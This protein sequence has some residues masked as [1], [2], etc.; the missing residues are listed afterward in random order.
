MSAVRLLLLFALLIAS[1][2]P[3]SVGAQTLKLIMERSP[4]ANFINPE[5][6]FAGITVDILTEV[7]NSVGV[8]IEIS[9]LPWRRAYQTALNEADTCVF[10]TA[11]LGTR[12]RLF[13]WV[14]PLTY[15]GVILYGHAGRDYGVTS[16]DDV[17]TKGYSV[18]VEQDDITHLSMLEVPGIR[19]DI[20]DEVLG[21]RKLKANRVD[22]W[23]GGVLT[24]IYTARLEGV[25]DLVPV[26]PIVSV[27]IMLAC[28]LRTASEPLARLQSGIDALRAKGRIAEIEKRYLGTNR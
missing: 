25:I 1:A 7:A 14:G 5:G 18:S 22:L 10:G 21:L 9:Q 26:L 12:E 4:P 24:G 17:V 8:S 11:R 15:G 13:K 19:L 3:S 28:N 23:A 6:H 20:S 16:I 2:H 27:D